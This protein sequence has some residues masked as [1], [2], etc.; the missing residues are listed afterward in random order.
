MS[1]QRSQ[2][3]LFSAGTAPTS[4]PEH[5]PSAVT[6]APPPSSPPVVTVQGQAHEDS[7]E[8][9]TRECL[10]CRCCDL[11]ATRTHVVISRGN[12]LARLMLIGEGPGQ[13]EDETGR[14][15]V[16]RAGQLLDQ[17]LTSVGL[18]QEQD[19][20]ICNVVKCRPPGN[21]KPTPEEMAY[22]RPW[23]QRQIQLVNPDMVLLAGATAMMG[24]LGIKTGITKMR[25]QWIE[26]EG[27]VYMPVFHPSFLL[28]N[29]SRQ[30]GQPKWLTW[31]D[32][33]AVRARLDKL[34]ASVQSRETHH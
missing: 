31:E 26:R 9:F 23:L 22:C 16:G 3:D 27:R 8:A 4:T 10:G 32:F 14:P 29:G 19:I 30:K 13:H 34:E 15:F 11:A 28:R 33:K 1:T 6:S 2:L 18:D 21:R 17:I 12:P 5:P 7:L 24:V 20:Y 25:G